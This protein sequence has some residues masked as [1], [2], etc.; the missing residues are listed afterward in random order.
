[1][2]QA[3]KLYSYMVFASVPALAFLYGGLYP[4]SQI[5]SF[6]PK[7]LLVMVFIM[8]TEGKLGLAPYGSF[9]VY[10]FPR[11]CFIG[12]FSLTLVPNFSLA[13]AL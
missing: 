7:L 13:C 10:V 1:M 11:T 9:F 2:K 8:G 6:F 3:S 4:V 12:S 5:K